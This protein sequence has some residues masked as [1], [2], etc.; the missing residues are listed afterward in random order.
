M[1]TGHWPEHAEARRR[2]AAIA[3]GL[4]CVGATVSR[5]H[6]YVSAGACLS[7]RTKEGRKRGR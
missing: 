4:D 1:V 7:Q 6:A 5:P 2:A 3:A